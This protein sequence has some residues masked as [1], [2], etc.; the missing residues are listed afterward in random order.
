MAKPE[1]TPKEKQEIADHYGFSKWGAFETYVQKAMS[2]GMSYDQV[3]KE[4]KTTPSIGPQKGKFAPIPKEVLDAALMPDI[5]GG[6]APPERKQFA[7]AALERLQRKATGEELSTV[8]KA[9]AAY[10][11]FEDLLTM[12]AGARGAKKLGTQKGRMAFRTPVKKTKLAPGSVLSKLEQEFVPETPEEIEHFRKMEEG[13]ITP[14]ENLRFMNTPEGARWKNALL[15]M[16]D[17]LY[18]TTLHRA[19]GTGPKLKPLPKHIESTLPFNSTAPVY[20]KIQQL[21]TGSIVFISPVEI[22]KH[23]YQETKNLP[24]QEAAEILE[25]KI[26]KFRNK[27]QVI[28]IRDLTTPIRVEQEFMS[29]RGSARAG[30][31][32]PSEQKIVINANS[33]LSDKIETLLHEI[34]HSYDTKQISGVLNKRKQILKD[35]KEGR[36]SKEEFEQ[37]PYYNEQQTLEENVQLLVQPMSRLME[38]KVAKGYS[39][40]QRYAL[41]QL[42]VGPNLWGPAR[43]IASRMGYNLETRRDI[44]EFIRQLREDPGKK[45]FFLGQINNTRGLDNLPEDP[46]K[47]KRHIKFLEESN[48]RLLDRM[49]FDKKTQLEWLKWV[50]AP[51]QKETEVA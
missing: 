41:S 34:T 24:D 10:N 31:Y 40:S 5:T 23:Y 29:G 44:G 9:Q 33:F 22:L 3:I 18:A 43:R 37:D 30:R 32:T 11:I 14:G 2:R 4:L 45:A 47:R 27:K 12:A 7:E 19:I 17:W 39:G 46:I 48:E 50:K 36:R 42:E 26:N 25:K 51:E 13:L 20:K 49:E 38:T 1:L 35:I 15:N 28:S 16:T 21:N 8:E 6:I